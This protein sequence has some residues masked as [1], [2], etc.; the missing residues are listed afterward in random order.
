MKFRKLRSMTG[1]AKVEIQMTPMLDM[2]FQLLIFFILTFKPIVD[3]GQFGA[4]DGSR[5]G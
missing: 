3:E 2:I 4:L 5:H 1:D